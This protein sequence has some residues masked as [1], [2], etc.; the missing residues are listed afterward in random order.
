MKAIKQTGKPG[1]RFNKLH[2][3]IPLTVKMVILTIIVGIALWFVLD[4]FFTNTLQ[5]IFHNHLS[6]H[7]SDHSREFDK[8]SADVILNARQERAITAFALIT[9]FTFSMYWITRH[10]NRI[11]WHISYF[12][13]NFLGLKPRSQM[14]GDQLHALKEQFHE[15]TKEIIDARRTIK[16]QA[17]EK[18]RLIVESAFDAIATTNDKGIISSWNPTAETLFGWTSE[19]AV[20]KPIYDVIIPTIHENCRVPIKNIITENKEQKSRCRVILNTYHR[21]GHE[22]PV[23]FSVSSASQDNGLVLIFIMR[24]TTERSRSKN[25]IHHLLATLTKAKNEW[26]MTFDSVTEQIMLVDKDLNLIR[27]NKSFADSMRSTVHKLIGSK[28][29]EFIICDPEWLSDIKAGKE[30]PERIEVKTHDGRWLYASTLPVNDENN[31]FMYTIITA[32]DIT[33]MKKTQQNLIESKEE[34]NDRIKELESFYDMAVNRELKMA[35]LKEQI[36]KLETNNSNGGNGS[37]QE[38]RQEAPNNAYIF[39][40]AKQ[41]HSN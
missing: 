19:E 12:S 30:H 4:H 23:E 5:N 29:Y 33:D 40:Q 41:N 32:T 10:I 36:Q 17:E 11:I 38:Q 15:L 7:L 39:N 8:L 6:E 28:C 18:T 3:Q 27:C 16:K 37:K 35:K 14:K 20:G 9:V 2:R 1:N 21:N 22:I 13:E 25:R 31:R 34:L 24:D 26:E